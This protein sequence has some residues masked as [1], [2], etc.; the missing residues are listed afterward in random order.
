[1]SEA[2]NKETAGSGDADATS[3]EREDTATKATG[4][5]EKQLNEQA[6]E[7]Q[8]EE[9]RAEQEAEALEQQDKPEEPVDP[10][11]LR[12]EIADAREDL[13]DTV[14]ALAAKTDVKA[15][16]KEKVEEG[17]DAVRDQQARAEAKLGEVSEQAKKNPVPF[18]AGGVVALFLLIL[19]LRR[20]R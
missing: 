10:D 16:A 11:Q 12:G 17:K 5:R 3:E 1:M 14:E 18:A 19:L 13:G 2:T 7:H 15:Q 20:R 6:A 8:A 4:R 9:K